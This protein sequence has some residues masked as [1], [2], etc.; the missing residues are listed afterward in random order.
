[1]TARAIAYVRVSTDEQARE[2][3]SLDAQADRIRAYCVAMDLELV[4]VVRDEG[5]TAANLNRPGIRGILGE[6]PR[7]G[8]RPWDVL[9]VC[10]L[11]RLT[12]SLR[13]LCSL[14]ES[15]ERGSVKFIS[16]AES[17]DTGSA[18]GRL[19]LNIVGALSQWER[20]VIGER[21]TE[22]LAHLKAQGK[23]VSRYAPFGSRFDGAGNVVP[24]AREQRALQDIWK[25][26]KAGHSLASISATLAERGITNR[27]GQPYSKSALSLILSRPEMTAGADF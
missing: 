2:G 24:L 19:F 9:I 1:M 23:R 16:L 17:V 4:G 25:L 7:P 13:D 10:K 26:R 5:K 6:V 18:S 11:D 8:K 27:N 12:R 3:V 20:E 21:T 14:V 22:A 15:F